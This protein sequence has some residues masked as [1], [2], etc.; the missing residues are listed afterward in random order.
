MKDIIT[1]VKDSKKIA[2]YTKKTS[3]D[4]YLYA[5]FDCAFFAYSSYRSISST[6]IQSIQE[7]KSSPFDKALDF[8]N[9]L[10]ADLFMQWVS[11][12]KTKEA[13]ELVKNGQGKAE[14][15]RRSISRVEEAIS[16]IIDKRIEF[17]LETEPL[18]VLIKVESKILSFDVLPDG[19]KS[20][21]SWVSNLLMR[22]DRI[23]WATND[24]VLDRRFILFLDEIDVHLHPAWQRK[25]LPAIQRL[26]K[27][28]QIF[29]ST[30]SPFVV[31]SIDGAWVHKLVLNKEEN[32]RAEQAIKS[33]DGKSYQYI[34]KEIFDIEEQF[35]I[36]TEELLVEFRRT[37]SKILQ[38]E[39]Y[40]KEKFL[41]LAHDIAVQSVE[42][43]SIIGMELRQLSRIKQTDFS[44]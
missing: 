24:D 3:S 34:L 13:V 10:N 14:R 19:L 18:S 26:F 23:A 8:N 5:F 30:H 27:N 15:Y 33:E 21:I 43:S 1:L 20:I 42:L 31:G 25:I 17:V 28:A 6:Q 32:G 41:K 22:L 37:K 2:D 9:S 4:E 29:V 36:G 11:V 40:D 12:N 39:K 16:G 44:I 38:D 35:G 7:L